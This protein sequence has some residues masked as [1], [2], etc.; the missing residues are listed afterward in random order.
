MAVK[1]DIKAE[2][3]EE[4][5]S[6]MKLQPVVLRNAVEA[7]IRS[8]T[9]GYRPSD[10]DREMFDM[11][12]W[13]DLQALPDSITVGSH[14]LSHPI[15]TSLSGDDLISEIKGSRDMLVAKMGRAVD[16]FCYP[17]GTNDNLVVQEVKKH[18]RAAVTTRAGFVAAGDDPYLL[19][20]IPA[21]A[22]LP[23]FAWRLIRPMA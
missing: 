4:V 13:S 5:V 8:M 1:F 15:L 14:T 17:N 23:M 2:S 19:K 21:A 18:Y 6:W 9:G 3:R 12:T 7:S 16:F 11:M 22:S 10:Q 20:R